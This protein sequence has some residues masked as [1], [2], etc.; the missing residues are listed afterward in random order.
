MPNSVIKKCSDARIARAA[1]VNT[2]LTAEE[3]GINEA[4]ITKDYYE[5]GFDNKYLTR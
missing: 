4:S 3:N 5:H 1:I 2:E